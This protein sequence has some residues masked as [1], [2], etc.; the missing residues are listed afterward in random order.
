MV[1]AASVMLAAALSAS[2][3]FAEAPQQ[4][5]SV[6]TTSDSACLRVLTPIAE[7]RVPDS[8][9]FQPVLCP[10]HR[11][12]PAFRYDTVTHAT[13]ATRPLAQ[14][15]VV[16]VFSE[17]GAKLVL[18]GQMLQLVTQSGAVRIIRQVEAM[19]AARSGERLFVKASDGQIFS[20]RYEA[21]SP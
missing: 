5:A 13:R 4:P 16:P 10:P 20:A 9:D 6:S 11:P 19:Q 2:A 17:F 3:A 14:N 21:A 15:E 7:G 18:P 1:V 12:A 8:A